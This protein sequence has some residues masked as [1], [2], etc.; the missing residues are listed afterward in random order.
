MLLCLCSFLTYFSISSESFAFFF[1]FFFGCL[2]FCFCFSVRV[3]CFVVW[4]YDSLPRWVRTPWFIFPF[5]CWRRFSLFPVFQY[6]SQR[7]DKHFCLGFL[8]TCARVSSVVYF[9]V[10]LLALRANTCSSLSDHAKLFSRPVVLIYISTSHKWE[11]P[12]R[13]VLSSTW[14]C[15]TFSFY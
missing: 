6:S 15:Q 10:K 12:L 8:Y 2:V 9:T 14:Y 11:F 4:S 3:I 5:F 1:F 7:C 13:H